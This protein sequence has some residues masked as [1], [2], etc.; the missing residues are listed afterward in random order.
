MKE[1]VFCGI[2]TALITP[3]KS[4]KIDYESFFK[5]IEMQLEAGTDALII[6]G[7]TGEAATLTDRE[8][9]ELY[10]AARV[11][12]EGK[13]K[14]ILGT[15]TNDT[16]V[17][18]KHTKMAEKIGCDGAL[19][20]TPYYNRG[21]REGVYLHYRT[22]AEATDLPIILYN[23][24]SRTGVGL[25]LETVERLAEMKTIVGI[26]EAQDST[27]RLVALSGIGGLALYA[28]ND[29]ATYT[30]LTLGGAGVISVLSN[31]Y[32]KQMREI[33]QKYLE[34]DYTGAHL[35]QTKLLPIINALFLETNPAPIKYAMA[36]AG[37]CT[38]E[39]RLPMWFVS[40][41]T[42]RRID[43]AIEKAEL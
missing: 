4:G 33:Y 9:Y 40:E 31:L 19:V 17:A 38:G 20:V 30:T 29:G 26:K 25:E 3:F 39:M 18:V 27:E 23:V 24:P 5:L 16:R 41:G 7:T 12:T 6:G 14:L 2:G 10:R 21:T 36:R 13:T 28:G 43:T 22:I 1:K 8:R 42:R 35:A 11:A 32:P 34:K 37:L 15:G